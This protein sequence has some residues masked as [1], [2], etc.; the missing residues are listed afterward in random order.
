MM[1]EAT[2]AGWDFQSVWGIFENHSYPYLLFEKPELQI[3]IAANATTGSPP[4]PVSFTYWASVPESFIYEWE[5]QFGDGAKSYEPNPSHVYTEFGSYTVSLTVIT[6]DG[7]AVSTQEIVVG[8]GLPIRTGSVFV[9]AAVMLLATA[10]RLQ[11]YFPQLN[12][13]KVA[14]SPK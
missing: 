3:K 5:W 11:A 1:R 14:R 8:N 2:F 6:Y 9:L 7:V 4:L 10:T 13:T 12:R